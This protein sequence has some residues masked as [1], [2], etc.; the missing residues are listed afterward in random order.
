MGRP[1]KSDG[2]KT[3]RAILASALRLFAE[4]GY[5]GTSLR[6]IARDVGVRESAL[7]NYFSGK[8]ALFHALIDAA[9]EERAERLSP[10][11]DASDEEPRALLERLTAFVL[12]HFCEPNAQHLFRLLMSDGMRL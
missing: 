8:E 5:F 9:H 6:D 1:P 11:L 12:D 4:K 7:Y 3:R 2:E 10:F